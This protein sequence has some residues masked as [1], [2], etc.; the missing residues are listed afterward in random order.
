MRDQVAAGVT[1]VGEYHY[2]NMNFGLC[3]ILIATLLGVVW[4]DTIFSIAPYGNEVLWDLVSIQAYQQYLAHRGIRP[5]RR[6]R[7][8]ARPSRFARAR[9][10]VSGRRQRLEFG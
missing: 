4:P 3:R 5:G 7:A 1:A 10:S 9:L 2:Q 6:R 8:D